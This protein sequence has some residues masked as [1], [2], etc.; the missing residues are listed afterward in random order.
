MGSEYK[1]LFEN[2]DSRGFAITVEDLSIT[3]VQQEVRD[4]LEL[5][6]TAVA[7]ISDKI[8]L[9]PIPGYSLRE[10]VLRCIVRKAY[11][12]ML[13]ILDLVRLRHSLPAMSLLRSM[14][15]E[16]IFAKFIKS[17]PDEDAETYLNQKSMLEIRQG[18]KAQAVFFS[19]GQSVHSSR[20]PTDYK[21]LEEQKELLNKLIEVP[22]QRLKELGNKLGW[23]KKE[24]PSI[25]NMAEKTE[26]LEIYNFF[27]HAAS[28]SVHASLH[29]LL[30]MV[31]GNPETGQFSITNMNYE[32]Y[33]RKVV[34]AYGA[35]L[36]AEIMEAV[37]DSFLDMWE[38]VDYEAYQEK[39]AFI[40]NFTP[41]IVTKEELNWRSA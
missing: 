23:G 2:K 32:R 34:I 30:R 24:S 15:E 36:F 28:S 20:N 27:Y 39:V 10:L 19:S 33:Y 3:T 21:R 35:T 13:A 18:L 41:P 31:W 26:S 11:E 14:C 5:A 12:S 29:N 7:K 25:R 22:K 8:E 17:L 6:E 38:G 9:T 37:K 40:V 16:L 1:S 4:M